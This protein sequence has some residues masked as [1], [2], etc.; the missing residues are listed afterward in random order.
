MY[1]VKRRAPSTVSIAKAET[2]G[3]W[4]TLH[5][6]ADAHTA[7]LMAVVQASWR[8]WRDNIPASALFDA[9]LAGNIGMSISIVERAWMGIQ[10]RLIFDVRPIMREIAEE[11]SL[12]TIPIIAADTGFDLVAVS[13][14][15]MLDWVSRHTGELIT[16]IGETERLAIRDVIREVMRSGMPAEQAVQRIRDSVGLT[17]PQSRTIARLKGTMQAAGINQRLI[18]QR[19]AARIAEMRTYRS[20]VIARNEALMASKQGHYQAWEEAGARG[21]V[22]IN[23]LRRHWV[24]TPL[25]VCAICIQIPG[26]NPEGRRIGEPYLTPVGSVMIPHVHIKCRCSEVY[27]VHE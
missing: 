8:T 20:E 24:V 14:S 16:Q 27:R 25:D 10:E 17:A 26:I 7:E 6:I 21:A 4:Q 9:I 1:V 15:R 13:R 22:N 5:G 12:V 11:A 2:E 19:L 18:N 3:F 23:T